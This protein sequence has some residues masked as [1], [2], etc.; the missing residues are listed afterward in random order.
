MG[1]GNYNKD[2]YFRRTVNGE[3]RFEHRLVM[4]QHLGRELL[5]GEEVHHRNGLRDD[6]R[7]DNLELW[8]KRGSQ[9]A[10]QRVADLIAF[11]VQR[12]PEQVA[13]AIRQPPQ[14]EA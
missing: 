6:N 7:I 12:Y 2:G 9:P 8:V 1:T 14:E 11:V 5:P 4:E 10:G 13:A 3:M